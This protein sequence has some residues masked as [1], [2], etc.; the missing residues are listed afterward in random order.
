MRLA[1]TSGLNR[2]MRCWKGMLYLL[3]AHGLYVQKWCWDGMYAHAGRWRHHL[4][5]PTMWPPMKA[6]L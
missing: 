6:F 4:R 2:V 5:A 1:F 3:C